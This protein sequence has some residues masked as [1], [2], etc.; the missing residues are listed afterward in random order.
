MKYQFF[1]SYM[2][3]TINDVTTKTSYIVDSVLKTRPSEKWH[4]LKQNIRTTLM[5]T[6]ETKLNHD[7]VQ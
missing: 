3:W 2:K 4:F 7:R 6:L 5:L 1:L